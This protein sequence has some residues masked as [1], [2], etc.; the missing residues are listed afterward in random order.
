[1]SSQPIPRVRSSGGRLR[2]GAMAQGLPWLDW[3]WR[4]TSSSLPRVL[5]ALSSCQLHFQSF[6]SQTRGSLPSSVSA[7]V[8]AGLPRAGCRAERGGRAQPWVR[9]RPSA[10]P[11]GG[12]PEASFLLP[13]PSSSPSAWMRGRSPACPRPLLPPAPHPLAPTPRTLQVLATSPLLRTLP[14]L[15]DAGSGPKAPLHLPSC[16]PDQPPGPSTPTSLH[17]RMLPTP[18]VS[19]SQAS[20]SSREPPTFLRCEVLSS[21]FSSLSQRSASQRGGGR[22]GGVS[23]TLPRRPR[24]LQG[25][26]AVNLE[27][28]P[29]SVGGWSPPGSGVCTCLSGRGWLVGLLSKL[30]WRLN[31]GLG[32]RLVAEEGTKRAFRRW[33]SRPARL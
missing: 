27:P 31:V 30:E 15:S 32:L 13:G 33:Q 29:L 8:S 12:R 18:T 22:K 6:S 10:Q 26:L 17:S 21:P 24:P 9:A 3:S 2:S 25:G 16:R 14:R 28:D 23:S 7:K 5:V 20:S 19:Q 4:S 11:P 1:M